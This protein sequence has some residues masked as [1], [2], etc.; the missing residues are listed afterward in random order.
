MSRVLATLELTGSKTTMMPDQSALRSVDL[1]L[2]HT[3]PV[4][5]TLHLLHAFSFA[6]TSYRLHLFSPL[7]QPTV[8]VPRQS[9]PSLFLQKS[10]LSHQETV[11][12]RLS[13]SYPYLLPCQ[14]SLRLS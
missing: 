14:G 2:G 3:F 6:T 7:E 4:V 13:L 8:V 1:Q 10:I 11:A 12:C 9:S 5:I